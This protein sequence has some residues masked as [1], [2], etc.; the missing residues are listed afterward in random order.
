MQSGHREGGHPF[1]DPGGGLAAARA[2][3]LCGPIQGTKK[4]ARRHGIANQP[5]D[6]ALVAV[7]LGD[8]GG[9]Q[10]GRQGIDLEMRRRPFDF[11]DEAEHVGHGEVVEAR[12]ER[13]RGAPGNCQ[14][15]EES[16]Q[17]SCLAEEEQFVLAAEVVIKVAGRQGRGARD[18]A[19]A[20]GGK[21]HLSKGAGGSPEDLDPACIGPLL[22]TL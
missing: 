10:A 18:V 2:V 14:R 20:G 9:A 11:V 19:H 4:G 1:G 17:R 13:T 21:S 15:R 3:P 22:E 5:P 12:R 6:A 8:D 7:A 16:V